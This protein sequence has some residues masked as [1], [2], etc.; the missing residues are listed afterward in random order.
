M[1]LRLVKLNAFILSVLDY[2]TSTYRQQ[3]KTTRQYR[4][5]QKILPPDVL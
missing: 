5:S 4:M 1:L 2:S 3:K